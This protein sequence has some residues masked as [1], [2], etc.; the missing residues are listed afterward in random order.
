[1]VLCHGWEFIERNDSTGLNILSEEALESK[2][3]RAR[4]IRN[5]NCYQGNTDVN[6]LQCHQ[7]LQ[8]ESDPVLVK[9]KM[10]LKVA[11]KIK[12]L[13]PSPGLL[14]ILY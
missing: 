6:L 10:G 11:I 4:N 3:P 13:E 14:A 2:H 1:M 5:F 8:L 9:N 7:H 12:E